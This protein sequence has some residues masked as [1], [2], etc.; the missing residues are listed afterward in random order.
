MM[1]ASVNLRVGS[2]I[3]RGIEVHDFGR[4]CNYT[5]VSVDKCRFKGCFFYIYIWAKLQVRIQKKQILNQPLSSKTKSIFTNP[6]KLPNSEPTNLVQHSF[7]IFCKGF[8]GNSTFI[9][10]RR[11]M[12]TFEFLLQCRAKFKNTKFQIHELGSTQH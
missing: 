4:I 8:F 12:S 6:S 1:R 9:Y 7:L 10:I 3:V 5:L 2:N 11:F